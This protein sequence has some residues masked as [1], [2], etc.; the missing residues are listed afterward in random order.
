MTPLGH[1][2]VS[3]SR[4]SLDAQIDA[5][6]APLAILRCRTCGSTEHHLISAT[7]ASNVYRCS[8]CNNLTLLGNKRASHK[9]GQ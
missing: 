1:A 9:A 4:Q 8:G 7:T 3:A 2:R 6:T 5:L